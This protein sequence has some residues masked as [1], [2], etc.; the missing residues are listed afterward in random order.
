MR[1]VYLP[2]KYIY[3]IIISLM[4]LDEKERK[5]T[6]LESP[7]IQELIPATADCTHPHGKVTC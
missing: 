2:V 4:L 3:Y 5:D 6:P 1:W 7:L